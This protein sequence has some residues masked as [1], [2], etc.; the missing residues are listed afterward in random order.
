MPEEEAFCVFVHLMEQYKLREIYKPSMADLS[1]R[2]YQLQNLVEVISNLF[3]L[4]IYLHYR[5]TFHV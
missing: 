1:V 3:A 2:F 5:N 4:V